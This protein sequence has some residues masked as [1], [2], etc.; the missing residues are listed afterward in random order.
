MIHEESRARDR[1]IKSWQ[2]KFELT[3]IIPHGAAAQIDNFNRKLRC[4]LAGARLVQRQEEA[5]VRRL[6]R[7]HRFGRQGCTPKRGARRQG[8]LEEVALVVSNGVARLD[9]RFPFVANQNLVA[10]LG[11]VG[12]QNGLGRVARDVQAERPRQ[13][14]IAG[15]KT[16]RRERW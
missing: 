14:R 12:H 4:F 16:K 11:D 2:R 9:E 7:P 10:G 5:A 13:F 15:A 8:D 6:A 1:Q 3:F